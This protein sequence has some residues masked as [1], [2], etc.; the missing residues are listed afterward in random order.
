MEL[1]LIIL[2]RLNTSRRSTA[3]FD[4]PQDMAP[5]TKTDV[6]SVKKHHQTR[7]P[8]KLEKLLRY[9][10]LTVNS[11]TGFLYPSSAEHERSAR[12]SCRLWQN[13]C[14]ARSR[15]TGL[16]HSISRKHLLRDAHYWDSLRPI[17][18]YVNTLSIAAN[19]YKYN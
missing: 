12:I 8:Y 2:V 17:R 7:L 11:S 18:K 10:D 3:I 16:S 14:C 4:S 9:F 15:E 1:F 6:S 13:L 5:K 19:D